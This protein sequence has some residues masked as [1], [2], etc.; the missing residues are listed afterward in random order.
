MIYK[1]L[2]ILSLIGCSQFSTKKMVSI[3]ENE[4]TSK[5][6]SVLA[7][8]CPSN[9]GKL[10]LQYNETSKYFSYTSKLATDKNEWLLGIEIPFRGEEVVLLN[11]DK[12]PHLSGSFIEQ[13]QEFENMK[14]LELMVSTFE[15]IKFSHGEKSKVKTVKCQG[16]SDTK[17]YLATCKIELQGNLSQDI[18]VKKNGSEWNFHFVDSSLNEV[19]MKLDSESEKT[20]NFVSFYEARRLGKNLHQEAM[21]ID[22][23]ISECL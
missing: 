19:I 20:F 15:W 6:N 23:S 10:K 8:T 14:F 4:M 12:A 3:S 11:W 18:E 13:D 2:I 16:Q 5:I 22:F 1:Y 9:E 17:N 21:K 7:K